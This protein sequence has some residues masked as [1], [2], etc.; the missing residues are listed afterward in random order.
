[1]SLGLPKISITFT[2]QASTLIDR[3]SR[4]ACA[5]ILNDENISDADGVTYKLIED[6]TDIPS[7]GITDSTAD[8]IKKALAG[9]PSKIHCYFIPLAEH[10]EEQV[11]YVESEV[12]SDVVVEHTVDSDVVITRDIDSDVVITNPDTGETET[13]SI[14]VTITDTEVQSVTYT[15]TETIQVTV[16]NPVTETV[17]VPAQVTLT[18]AL[19]KLA[20]VRFNYICHP[21]GKA[22]DQR[23]L[24]DW[25]KSQRVNKDRTVKAVVAHYAANDCGVINFTTDNIK[26]LNDAYTAALALVDGD[27]SAV[28][29]PKYI[30]YTATQYTARIAG[31]LAGLSLDRSATYYTLSEVVSV[32][33]YEDIESNIDSGE[34][35]L[36]DELDGNGVKIARGCNSLTTF[37]SNVGQDFRFIKIVETLDIIKD[38]IRDTFRNNYVGKVKNSYDNKILLISAINTY[39]RNLQATVLD[40]DNYVEIDYNKNLDYAKNR[41]ED[42]SSLS[43]QTILSYNTGTYVYLRGK[44]TPANAMEDLE[45][46]FTLN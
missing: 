40:G 44:I 21:T 14:S 2:S 32:D 5:M 11:S 16:T 45:L 31:I 3:S 35:C 22:Q 24:A 7:S 33:E 29:V 36:F 26:L 15:D 28:D 34:L 42:V 17:I 18:D 4:G 13:Q 20:N 43:R 23:D 46:E 37:T 41:G 8:L 9:T 25:V 39:L 12:E 19:K 27:E 10:E 6:S 1:M 30:T 38:D